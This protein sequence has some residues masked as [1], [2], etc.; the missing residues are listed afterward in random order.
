MKSTTNWFKRHTGILT[1]VELVIIIGLATSTVLLAI[2]KGHSTNQTQG[3]S[4]QSSTT[5]QTATVTYKLSACKSGATQT[6][7]NASYVVGT[8]IAP[9][10]Y[11][12]KDATYATDSSNAS[13]SNIS[14]YTSKSQYVQMGEPSNEKT[15][16]NQSF[17][18][19]Y[20]DSSYTKLS[21]GQYMVVDADP[22]TFTCQ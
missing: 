11:A 13:W 10:N 1:V 22:A 15:T 18:T 5:A 2:S 21:D 16:V 3:S 4:Q 17:E 8:D 7:G 12:V 19:S 6:V 14:V 20:G 9:G